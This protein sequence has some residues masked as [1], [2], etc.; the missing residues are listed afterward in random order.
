MARMR[1]YPLEIEK[2]HLQLYSKINS[3]SPFGQLPAEI[4]TEIFYN[5]VNPSTDLYGSEGPVNPFFLGKICHGW[6]DFVWSTPILWTT[7]YLQLSM[8]HYEA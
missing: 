2:E 4:K 7:L 3:L 1:A 6:R 5:A 8:D